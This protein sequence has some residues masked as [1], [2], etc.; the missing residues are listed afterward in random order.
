MPRPVTI[1]TGQWWDL[2]LEKLC[3][4]VAVFGYDGVELATFCEHFNVDRAVSEDSYIRSRQVILEKY[5]L[6][7]Y[8]ISNHNTGQAVCDPIDERIKALVSPQIWGD[9]KEEGVRQRA[10]EEMK[11]T[12]LAARLMGVQVVNGFTGSPIWQ[13]MY[14]YP[15][16]PPDAIEKG[17]RFFADLWNPI[18]DEYDKNDVRFAL[19]VHPT[20]IA[21]DIVTAEKAVQALG[22]R[23]AFGFNYDPSHLG[24][25]GVDYIAFIR[26]FGDRIYHCHVKDVYWSPTPTPAGVFGGHL[27]FGDPRRYWNFRSPGRGSIDFE[28]IIRSLND[29]GYSGPLSVEWEDSRMDRE[30]GAK[31]ACAYIKRLDFPHS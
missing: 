7:C 15:P 12:A 16:T 31:E 24:Y 14:P 6:K 19:E 5:G 25:Q 13:Y 17:Y 26:C 10:C 2:P 1:Y 27:E 28:A 30:F 18:L 21:F 8:A 11:R 23:R 29:A 9:G 20:E 22:G 3:E 4:K